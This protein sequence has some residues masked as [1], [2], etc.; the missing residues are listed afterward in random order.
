MN[1]SMAAH[2]KS[3]FQKESQWSQ[4]FKEKS[5]KVTSSKKVTKSHFFQYFDLSLYPINESLAKNHLFKKK[6]TESRFFKKSHWKSL[7]PIFWPEIVPNQWISGCSL[8]VTYSKKSH[9]KSLI[10]KKVTESHFFQY[11]DLKLCPINESMGA[12]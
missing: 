9:W 1:E 10:K 6:V 12:H 11:S 5:L 2:W 4:L 7:F 8:K 3:P